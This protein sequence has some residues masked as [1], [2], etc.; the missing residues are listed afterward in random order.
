LVYDSDAEL[1]AMMF[2]K[3]DFK[4][5]SVRDLIEF[6][7]ILIFLALVAPFLIAAYTLGFLM[8][9]TGWLKTSS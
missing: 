9:I 2:S 6:L 8:D 3:D 4:V 5:E 7:P 1:V